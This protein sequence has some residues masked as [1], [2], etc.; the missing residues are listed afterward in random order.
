M[1]VASSRTCTGCGAHIAAETTLGL[2]PACALRLALDAGGASSGFDFGEELSAHIHSDYEL[3]E[4]I[5]RGGMGVVFRARQKSLD[6]IVALKVLSAGMFAGPDDRKSLLSEAA[7]AAR[8]QHPNIVAVHATG[9]L[10]G[11]PFYAMNFVPGR[12]L[13]EV[14]RSGLP[15]PRR[16]ASWLK[17]IAGAVQ[18][19][20]SQNVLHRDLKP[21]NILLDAA[22]EPRITDFGL[23]KILNPSKAA[24]LTA[25]VL[26][27][28]AYMPPEQAA[29]RTAEM[30]PAADVYSLGTMFYELLTGRP[31]FQGASPQAV[32]EQVKNTEPVAPRRLNPGVPED[33]NTVVLKCLEKNPAQRYASAQ[34]LADELERFLNGQPV[35]ARPIGPAEKIWR[36]SRRHPL[37]SALAVVSLLLLLVLSAVLFVSSHRVRLSR[38]EAQ[39]RLADSLLSEAHALRLAGEPGWRGR[40]LKDLAEAQRRDPQ[41]RLT[42]QLRDEA[43]A[44]LAR[45]DLARHIV[46]N[47]P[48]MNNLLN[49]CFDP[50]FER[51]AWWNPAAGAV[52]IHRVADGKLLAV[53]KTGEPDEV[54]AF[55]RDGKFLLL[56]HGG[57]VSVWNAANG[58]LALSG[59]ASESHRKFNGGEFSPD[60]E[61]FGRGETNGQFAIYDLTVTPPVRVAQW[62]LPDGLVCATAAWSADGSALALALGSHTLVLCDA[63]SGRV[64]WRRNYAEMIWNVTWNNARNWLAVES[65]DDRVLILAADDGR[66]LDH[67]NLLANGT[68]V[69]QL[70][71]DGNFLAASG[72]NFGTHIFDAGT[73]RLLAAD[74]A[75][76][77][78]LQFD[79]ASTRL[80]SQ[81]EQGRPL[82]LEWLPPLVQTTWHSPRQLNE[83]ERVSYNRDG[84][85]LASLIGGGIVIWDSS[86]GKM[87]TQVPLPDS[88]DVAFGPQNRLYGMSSKALFAIDLSKT[89][90]AENTP[91]LVLAGKNL[92]SLAVAGNGAIAVADF[93]RSQILLR[94]ATNQAGIHL[95]VAPLSLA[96][97][98]DGHWL[99]CGSEPDN[100]IYIC[101][102]NQPKVSPVRL[103]HAGHN[104]VFSADGRRLFTF[105]RE[106]R[107]WNV[108]DWQ[109]EP[110][111]LAEAGGGDPFNGAVSRS[112]FRAACLR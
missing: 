14:I 57:A 39:A 105:G 20:H 25:R 49:V 26:G 94:S 109:A 110:S 58:A 1:S 47:L 79:A 55:N 71:P 19:A 38:D 77:W 40:S 44:C 50:A 54:H 70:S 45:P 103:E 24:T 90:F 43:I 95:P 75:P 56:R 33:L 32:I 31:P 17:K 48:P 12:T 69:A 80:G 73:R 66:E 102:A 10:D 46:T 16:S 53:C 2:C 21:S 60:G 62:P 22:G 89:N 104:A 41:G 6:R 3:L 34:E 61:K 88:H 37:P 76:A 97:N 83:N 7:T 67:L 68:P 23:A 99:A 111:L 18:Y 4:E 74:P 9:E 28:P 59:V 11:H 15:P 13:A 42:F 78:H 100:D 35:R 65:G 29:G 98:P 84:S 86:S 8:L 30:G 64:R 51:I 93:G 85:R 82:W 112:V 72:E 107:V 91:V 101:D 108:G 96:F 27:S 5:G 63:N 87:M 52:V 81:L 106:V 92:R 36:W